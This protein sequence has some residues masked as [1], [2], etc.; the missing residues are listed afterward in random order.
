MSETL[1]IP[2]RTIID[3]IRAAPSPDAPPQR[4]APTG[5][6]T[7]A[8]IEIIRNVS[9]AITASLHIDQTLATLA[10]KAVDL[11]HA[12][13][14]AVYLTERGSAILTLKTGCN[15][16]EAYTGVTLR[17]NEDAPGRAAANGRPFI[18]DNY[19]AW[20]ERAPIFKEAAPEGIRTHTNCVAALPIIYRQYVLGVLEV[21]YDDGREISNTDVALLQLITPHAATAIAHAQLFE[22]NQQ[23]LNLLEVINDRSA[24]VS[25]VSTAV[26]NAGHN[27]VN[28]SEEVL[29]RLATALRMMAGK[30]FLSNNNGATLEATASYHFGLEDDGPGFLHVAQHCAGVRQTLLLQNMTTFKWTH[31]MVEWLDDHNFGP[32]VCV[33]LIAENE[34]VGVLQ[35]VAAPGKS[36]DTG[37][38]DTLHIIA[39]QLALGVSNA[40]L[41]RRIQAEQQQMSAI[42]SSSGDAIIGLDAIGRVQL[43]NPA[44]ERAFGFVAHDA[45]GR[46]LSEVVPNA[47]LIAAAETALKSDEIKPCAF[48][49]PLDSGEVLFCNLSPIVDPLGKLSGWVAVMQDITRFKETERLKSDMIL[50]A[51]HDLRN[52]VNLAL[53][54]LDL[55]G[56]RAD[57]LSEIQREALGLAQMGVRRIEALIKD[58][59]DLERI[60]RGVGLNLTK[61]DMCEIT[62]AVIT[63]QQ[64]VAEQRQQRLDF[65]PPNNVDFSIRG[66]ARR[67][68]QV[69]SNLV[70]NA[71]KYTPANGSVTVLLRVQNG[72]VRL[73]VRDT[74]AGISPEAQAHIFER[75][76]RAPAVAADE[77][78][79][80]LGL[81]IVKSIVEQHGGRVWVNSIAGQ[82]STFS[83]ALPCWREPPSE[84]SESETEKSS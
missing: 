24:A 4:P 10:E 43:A 70:S 35:T 8:E 71:I 57:N 84:N 12:P 23:V 33:P 28:M 30:V 54:A 80:G 55:M 16:P 65:T 63:E 81:A 5:E 41:F 18:V 15:I 68:Y 78:G 50:T 14:S 42:L 82:G 19:A 34:L 76:Y 66:D 52:P 1:R 77:R 48:E 60:E 69:A 74:G 51:S 38:L 61:C 29:T 21:M 6:L 75:F 31:R 39:G 2:T 7:H 36:F 49:V 44:A 9:L 20:Q 79:T 45:A 56:K 22:R 32:M 53:G 3:R 27:L 17:P 13:A 73:D 72:E 37:E 11:M 83:V 58:L 47:D 40:Y 25:S 46:S 64:L 59:L 26:I 62:G 67:L